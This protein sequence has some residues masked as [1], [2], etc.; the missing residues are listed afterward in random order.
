MQ[1]ERT[2]IRKSV[3]KIYKFDY[4]FGSDRLW[5]K[6]VQRECHLSLAAS[7]FS[8]SSCCCSCWSDAWLIFS[9][10]SVDLYQK[11]L[12]NILQRTAMF[13]SIE[14]ENILTQ[15]AISTAPPKNPPGITHG[16]GHN[17]AHGGK[18]W[19]GKFGCVSKGRRDTIASKEISWLRPE[20]TEIR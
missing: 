11:V 14:N 15:I 5:L 3:I 13:Y 4:H 1:L 9:P 2:D 7:V 10:F 18:V 12:C 8:S 16:V 17:P 6:A 20:V 19:T